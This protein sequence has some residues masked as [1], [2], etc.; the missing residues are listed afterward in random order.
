MIIKLVKVIFIYLSNARAWLLD[1]L[2]P[3]LPVPTDDVISRVFIES[4]VLEQKVAIHSGTAAEWAGLISSRAK[5]VESRLSPGARDSAHSGQSFRWLSKT[6]RFLG[7]GSIFENVCGDY[8]LCSSE[9]QGNFR[10][11]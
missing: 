8:A 1:H 6:F 10:L 9:G 3:S 7:H 5:P 4:S 2:T 11:S